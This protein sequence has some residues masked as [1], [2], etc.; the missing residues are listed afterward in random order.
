MPAP[1]TPSRPAPSARPKSA[2]HHRHSATGRRRRRGRAA[3]R[4]PPRRPGRARP[5]PPRGARSCRRRAPAAGRRSTRWRGR[6]MRR[7]PA[8]TTGF[9]RLM[10]PRRRTRC[11]HHRALVQPLGPPRVTELAPGAQHVRRAG[12]RGRRR[13][14]PAGHPVQPD[15]L[16]PRDRRLLQ[17]ELADQHLPRRDAGPAPRQVALLALVPAA[18]SSV[19]N[20]SSAA[21]RHNVGHAQH[22]SGDR[23]ESTQGG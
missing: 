13:C 4:K 18:R 19:A 16:N 7:F 20:R 5:W 2:A 8:A 22:E 15:G 6:C 3:T 10:A 21:L 9:R 11:D 12:R 17:H 23:M 1:C 14:R